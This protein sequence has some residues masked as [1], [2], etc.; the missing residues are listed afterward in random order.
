MFKQALLV[1]SLLL[2]LPVLAQ[3]AFEPTSHERPVT[4]AAA[5]DGTATIDIVVFYQPVYKKRL[6]GF[7]ALYNR[8][9]N[10][11]NKVNDIHATSETGVQFNVIELRAVTG[12]PDDQP[13]EEETDENGDVI[14]KSSNSIFSGR[15]LNPDGYYDENGNYQDNYPEYLAYTQFGAD[16]GLYVTDYRDPSREDKLGAASQGGEVSSIADE[17]ILSPDN[18]VVGLTLAH[19]LGH[20]LDAHHEEGGGRASAT[21]DIARAYECDGKQ[22]IMWSLGSASL[23][24][25]HLF[26]SSSEANSDGMVCG[27]SGYA[28]N[29]HVIRQTK[30]SASNRR[31]QPLTLG[32]VS[33]TEASYTAGENQGFAEVSLTR[34]GDISEESSVLLVAGSDTGSTTTDLKDAHKRV[35]FAPGESTAIAELGVVA[36]AKN[37]GDEQIKLSLVYPYKATVA[38]GESTLTLMDDYSGSPGDFA[39]NDNISVVE[40]NDAKILITRSNGLDG[41]YVVD[42]QSDYARDEANSAVAEDFEKITERLVFSDGESEKEIAISTKDDDKFKG[43]RV[44]LVRLESDD[45]LLDETL[46]TIEDNEVPDV[47]YTLS[48]GNSTA[49]QSA[50]VTVSRSGETQGESSISI[51]TV[52][53]SL[54][55]GTD[56]EALDETIT[57]SS[58]DTSKSVNI[59]LLSNKTGSFSVELSNGESVSVSVTDSGAASGDGGTSGGSMGL[60]LLIQISLLGFI[61]KVLCRRALRFDD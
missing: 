41:E 39:L 61:K 11:I 14:V 40:G 36:D 4:M 44:F 24:D 33:F 53:G 12:I 45:E 22:T 56:F 16:I 25:K 51:S 19:E 31:E 17:I 35:T 38:G 37:E 20:N 57:F 27:E 2:S 7:E 54:V 60:F 13:Y 46:V 3:D 23:S 6:G 43:D 49:G 42:I 1:S 34:T 26:F 50:T 28:D 47:D 58:G 52:D 29:A 15:L 48:A 32:S 55:S 21:Y 9:N 8:V 18:E 30:A 5:S 59:N 10:L